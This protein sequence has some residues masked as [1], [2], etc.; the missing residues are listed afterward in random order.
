M[1]AWTVPSYAEDWTVPGYTEERL[2]GRGVSGKVVGAVNDAT[3]QRVAIK[4]LSLALVRDPAFMWGF[5]TEAQMLRSLGVPQVVQ[6]YDFVEEPGQGAAVVMEMISGVSLRELLAHRGPVGP[7][8]ALAV[9]KSSLLGL[10]A[11]HTLGIV[12]RDYRPENILLDAAGN[13]KLADFGLAVKTGKHALSA[14]MP[15]YMAPEQWQGAPA[16]PA[17]D[18]YAA[19][20]VFFQ[21][22]NGKTPFSG[23]P[24]QLRE[25]HVTASVPVDRVGEPLADLIA[26]GMAKNPARR[27]SSAIAFVAEIEAMAAA[28]YGP[29]WEERGRRQLADRA[30]ALL[31]L[32]GDRKP[33]S[34]DASARRRGGRRRKALSVVVIAAAAVVV[35]A[36]AATAVTLSGSGHQQNL[37]SASQVATSV[38]PPI[39]AVATVTPPVAASQCTK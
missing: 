12:H 26:R 28:A 6:V 20:A 27:P 36:V 17:T 29:D 30:T 3:G 11:A 31:A 39:K 38:T 23:K 8:A 2:L 37:N 1:S 13:S 14:G 4:Y 35:L 22:L 21:C 5:R 10:A 15:L 24:N 7:E 34:A 9:L 25:Q 32:L 16:S 18:I 19:T 33:G